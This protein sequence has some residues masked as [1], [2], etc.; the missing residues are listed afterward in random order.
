MRQIWKYSKTDSRRDERGEGAVEEGT[1]FCSQGEHGFL[2]EPRS[3]VDLGDL[4]GD[5]ISEIRDQ[6]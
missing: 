3:A 1:L 6:K 2:F 5:E 4:T